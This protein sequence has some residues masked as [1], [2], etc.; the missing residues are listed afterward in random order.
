MLL[1]FKVAILD[2]AI[3][4]KDDVISSKS[5]MEGMKNTPYA[6]EK[7]FNEKLVESHCDAFAQCGFFKKE[8]VTVL[9]NGELDITYKITDYGIDRGNRFIPKRKK[10]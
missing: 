10:K 4:H 2:W 6:K 1:P 3:D 9:N 8:T 7:Q 5:I